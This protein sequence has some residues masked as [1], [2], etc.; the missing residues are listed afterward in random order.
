[1]NEIYE[2]SDY[3]KPIVTPFDIELALNP[4]TN[5]LEFSYDYNF[6]LPDS[7]ISESDLENIKRMDENDVSLITGK[8]RC[9][10]VEETTKSSDSMHAREVALRTDGTIAL[11]T[12]SGAGFL[13]ERSWKGLEQNLGV[14]VPEL[15]TEGRRG[16]A[17]G[18]QN[19]K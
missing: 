6:Y 11:N 1:M 15:A 17:Q 3:Y 16:I 8:V 9:S 2:S 4:Q 19:E 14:E 7:D 10:K 13:Q 12:N 18:Y 5:N